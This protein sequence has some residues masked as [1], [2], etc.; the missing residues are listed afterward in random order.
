MTEKLLD[1]AA[2]AFSL[3]EV[4]TLAPVKYDVKLYAGDPDPVLSLTTYGG[5]NVEGQ[6]ICVYEGGLKK[7]FL[8]PTGTHLIET[9]ESK[10]DP[11]TDP[12]ESLGELSQ[13]EVDLSD[14]LAAPLL[15]DAQDQD[16]LL[17]QQGFI[18]NDEDMVFSNDQADAAHEASYAHQE[19]QDGPTTSGE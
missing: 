15:D 9:A 17:R 4:E 14:R 10:P 8:I 3:Q 18:V 16:V 11:L 5:W 1:D 6:F 13:E 2:T 7:G 12:I 19:V